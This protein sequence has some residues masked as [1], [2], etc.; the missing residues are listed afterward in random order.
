[1]SWSIN[2]LGPKMVQNDFAPGFYVEHFVKDMGIALTEC[3]RMD[4][5]LP[6][7]AL[8]R[9]LYIALKAQGHARS[10]TQ[11]LIAALDVLSGGQGD[12]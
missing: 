5:S 4:L 1:A 2:N 3:E 10:G 11:A 7:L 8:V 9:Q 12:Y 6:G